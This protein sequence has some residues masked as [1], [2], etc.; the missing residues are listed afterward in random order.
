MT[1]ERNPLSLI[2]TDYLETGN[3]DRKSDV[4][5]SKINRYIPDEIKAKLYR[6]ASDYTIPDDN[7]KADM[8][9]EIMRP[10][11]FKEIGTGTNRIAFMKGRYCYKVALDDRG[12]IDNISEY[13]RSPEF[14]QYFAKVYETNRTILVCEYC[15]LISKEDFI[16]RKSEIKSILTKLSD[17]YIMEDV[18]L[19]T[20]NYCNWAIRKTSIDP[21]DTGQLVL[22][23][24]AYFY[25]I[26]NKHSILTCSCGHPIKP[27]SV[28]TGYQCTNSACGL[29]YSVDEILNK[30]GV[31]FDNDDTQIIAAKSTN[32][33]DGTSVTKYI[34]ITGNDSGEIKYI[35]PSNTELVN[36]ISENYKK[37]SDIKLEPEAKSITDALFD[38]YDLDDIDTTS[39]IPTENEYVAL[40]NE[41]LRRKESKL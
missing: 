33:E 11:G 4:I 12:F 17:F 35:D 10:L 3:L 7:E 40:N 23:D 31:D 13:K 39:R 36:K 24:N 28:F 20:K 37:A 8:I 38:G 9:K 30:V 14:P 22:I 6:I 41:L 2:N 34:S 32:V 25:P 19:V 21:D 27:N 16:A 5:V 29:H 15:E 26:R 18:G 1:N